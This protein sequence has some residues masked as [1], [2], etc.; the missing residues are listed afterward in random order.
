VLTHEVGEVTVVESQF[1]FHVIKVTG[2]LDP[3]KKVR[4]AVIDIDISPSQNTYQEIYAQAS[5]FQGNASSYEAFDTLSANLGIQKRSATYLEKMTNRIAGLDYPRQIIQWAYIEDLAVDAVSPVF[6]MEEKYVVAILT[7]IR[8][9]GIPEMEDVRENL[10]P[11]VLTELKGDVVVEQMNQA[12]AGTKDLVQ[13]ASELGSKVDTVPNV[14]FAS[15][16]IAGYGNETNLTA[17][18]FSVNPG[19]LAGPIKGNNAAFVVVV[20]EITPPSQ[21]ENKRIYERQLLMN[22]RSKVSNNSYLQ[23]LEEEAD[24][25]DNRVKFY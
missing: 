21:E 11:L 8:E 24:I 5:E 25:T 13:L 6:T 10:E 4:V 2:K 23:V 1:G 16:N 22:F 9:K 12:L 17:T 19:D 20:D 15:R 3:I 7:S 18:I 14:T